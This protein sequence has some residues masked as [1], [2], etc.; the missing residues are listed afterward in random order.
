MKKLYVAATEQHAGKTSICLGLYRAAQE[1]GCKVCFT[2]P[3]GQRYI[4]TDG[5]KVDEDAVL[6]KRALGA[7][8]QIKDLNPISIPRG[9]TRHYIFHRDESLTLGAIEEAFK[10]V[11]QGKDLVIIEGT[12]HAGAGSVLDLSNARVAKRLGAPVVLLVPAGIARSIDETWLNQCVFEREGVTLLGVVVNRCREDRIGD[13]ADVVRRGL[14]HKGIELLGVLPDSELL[15]AHSVLQLVMG[16][17][18]E[19]LSGHEG[20]ANSIRR[21]VVGAMG[22]HQALDSFSQNTL[23]ITPSERE[24]LILAALS[25]CVV[26]E[27]CTTCVG[28]ILLTGGVKPHPAIMALMQKTSIPVM[29][30]EHDSYTAAA[31]VYDLVSKIR[32]TDT[33]KISLCRRLA[34]RHVKVERLLECARAYDR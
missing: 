10:R 12:G 19:I 9:F 8:G 3:V 21:I 13:I 24:D 5:E 4:L 1:R 15:A 28:A 25:T 33:K 31:K 26:E 30:V 2:K 6:F 11:A 29:L 20:I 18:A 34:Q 23:L 22:P 16:L 27:T 14:A 32:P 17:E 7:H